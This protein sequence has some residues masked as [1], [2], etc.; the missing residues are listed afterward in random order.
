M[1]GFKNW[2]STE[3]LSFKRGTKRVNQALRKFAEFPYVEDCRYHPCKVTKLEPHEPWRGRLD[4]EVES[5]VNSTPNACSY[6]SCGI[7]H[8]T[9]EEG[10]E[11]VAFIHKYGMLPYT[12]KYIYGEAPSRDKVIVSIRYSMG[13]ELVWKFN[14]NNRTTEITDDGKQWLFETYEVV[15]DELTAYTPEEMEEALNNS[16]ASDVL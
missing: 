6:F 14:E 3:K 10:E 13:Q 15:W 4:V 11:R 9:K 2:R 16:D 1:W 12:L 8:L 7:V 5:L